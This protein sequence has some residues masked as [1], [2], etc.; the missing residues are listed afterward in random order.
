MVELE[1]TNLVKNQD[2]LGVILTR[3]RY[4]ICYIHVKKRYEGMAYSQN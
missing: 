1:L 3:I 4:K 2:D